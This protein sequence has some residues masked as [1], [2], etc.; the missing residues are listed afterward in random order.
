MGG[1]GVVYEAL[2]RQHNTRVAL[3]T[4]HSAHP[5][6]LRRLKREF[7]ELQGI[8]HPNLIRLGELIEESGQW[9]FTMELV[10]GVPFLE[11]VRHGGERDLERLRSALGE[12]ARG[13]T[14]LHDAGCIHR[15]IKP[16]NVLVTEAGR[17]VLLDFGFV[18]TWHGATTAWSQPQIVGTAAYMAPEQAASGDV[19]P[20]ADWY[21]VG[22]MVYEALTGRLPF[23]GSTLEIL[24]AKQTHSPAVPNGPDDLI[25]L[26][27]TLLDRDPDR[28]MSAL[29][30][31]P[32]APQDHVLTTRPAGASCFVG[33]HDELEILRAAAKTSAAGELASVL[34]EGESGIGKTSLVRRC[35]DELAAEGVVVLRSRCYERE[36]VPYRA[37]DGLIDELARYLQSL[38]R[39]RAAAFIPR[40][41]ALLSQ[42]FPVLRAVEALADTPTVDIADPQ[43]LRSRLFG[44]VR[45]LFAR[46][47]DR[48]PV[49]LM[50]D[51]LQW[52]DA[53]SLALL[54][55]LAAPP[56]APPLLLIGTW[57]PIKDDAAL[58]HRLEQMPFAWQ[59]LPLGPLARNAA[60]ELARLLL[61]RAFGRSRARDAAALAAE[62][63][64]HPLFIESLVQHAASFE[65]QPAPTRLEHALLQRV[66]GLDAD[67]RR[68]LQ[69]VAVAGGPVDLET[70]STA[71]D[72]S[73]ADVCRAADQ[74]RALH[75]IAG[76]GRN[77][78][79]RLEPYHDRV[80]QAVLDTIDAEDGPSLHRALARALEATGRGEPETLA[81]HHRAAG[82]LR[83]AAV[84]ARRA[85]EEAGRVLAF[86]RAAGLYAL[87]LELLGDGH[88]DRTELLIRLGDEL[89]KA[90]RG[91][92]AAEALLQA[93]SRVD[94]L[95]GL[96][97]RQRACEQLM[98]TG[99]LDEAL[100]ELRYISRAL[101]L[102][103]PETPRRALLDVIIGRARLALRRLRRRPRVAS[104]VAPHD[105]ARIELCLHAA[106]GLGTVDFIRGQSFHGTGMLLALEHGDANQLSRALALEGGFRACTGKRGARQAIDIIELAH[107][108]AV[109]A[110]DPYAMYEPVACQSLRCLA[111]GR[112]AD[113]YDGY[114]RADHII[115]EQCVGVFAWQKAIAAHWVAIVQFYTGR[116]RELS[117]LVPAR[118]REAEERGNLY[119][120]TTMQVASMPFI[121]LIANDPDGA[122][123]EIEAG[124][125][126]W[127]SNGTHLQHYYELMSRAWTLL[128]RGDAAATMRLVDER[129]PVLRAAML[130]RMPLI[131]GT[132]TEVRARAALARAF[133]NEL[134]MHAAI[135][136]VQRAQR[137]LRKIDE[138][139]SSAF[140]VALDAGIATLRREDRAAQLYEEAARRF[141]S[142]GM[143]LHANAASF[144]AGG[145]QYRD[146]R[147]WFVEQ[148]VVDV[149]RLAGHLMPA[150]HRRSVAAPDL[151]TE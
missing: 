106:V 130:L 19:G 13:V 16:S 145:E 146:A 20:A 44:A 23:D 95:R 72:T 41:A 98:V 138:P 128:Y 119:G 42:V 140:A 56:D 80:C 139:W 33:R 117:L 11:Y 112:F 25:A 47:T 144:R 10:D 66:T 97:L 151:A 35:A 91:K 90:G 113:A 45:E 21:S 75:L 107:K 28:R 57:R 121:R 147:R 71:L 60:R 30:A 7:R 122:L 62:A 76:T 150:W 6:A 92:R 69:L 73:L 43:E 109:E 1:M 53:D 105:R 26:C 65:K 3:K 52:A 34:V 2:D 18:T 84:H 94:E 132:V 88:P 114:R 148:G 111:T 59:R 70:L 87:A 38:P 134:D 29:G 141:A 110:G 131:A 64:G 137:L 8:E 61:E 46:L 12:L 133:A 118:L 22:V 85:A 55:N 5:D 48:V 81:T 17:V 39:D 79:D 4:L 82:D 86:D 143:M 127:T 89:Q 31:L 68:L 74:L 83:R 108:L 126:R 142:T 125:A 104:E 120:I 14:A 67:A 116:L 54:S 129:A 32:T 77:T 136:D 135:V 37:V 27:V 40:R 124:M 51:D 15:D 115:R 96:E 100:D 99:H 149:D 50:I 36:S 49:A 93:A 58:R 102:H 123:A 78:T 101:G 9:F 103:Y 24:T 63:A